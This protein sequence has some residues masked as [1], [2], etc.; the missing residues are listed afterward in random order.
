VVTWRND[1][2]STRVDYK[3]MTAAHPAI[4]DAYSYQRAGARRM[5][6]VGAEE[7]DTDG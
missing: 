2:P 1:R 5:L 4:A 6:V 3:A 7:E